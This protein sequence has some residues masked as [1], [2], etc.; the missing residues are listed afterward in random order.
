MIGDA[1]KSKCGSTTAITDLIG[2][3]LFPGSAPPDTNLPFGV[4]SVDVGN[5]EQHLGGAS[6]IAFATVTA[7]WVGATPASVDA[8]AEAVRAVF[9]GKQ[10]SIGG[11]DIRHAS[12]TDV[13][14]KE[15]ELVEGSQL[16]SFTHTQAWR[17]G[18]RESVP[19]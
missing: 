15:T 7:T 8:I 11:L 6:G 2:T 1:F 10:Q 14:R 18:Y 4:Y 17:F 12:L 9:H 3:R 5:H 16:Y 13:Q 19:A